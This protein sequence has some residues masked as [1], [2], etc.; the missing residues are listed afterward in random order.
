MLIKICGKATENRKKNEQVEHQKIYI[1]RP[2]KVT[3][4]AEK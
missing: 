3:I 2:S 1:K 4:T